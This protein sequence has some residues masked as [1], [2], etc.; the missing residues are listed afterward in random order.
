LSFCVG[1]D[2]NVKAVW[3]ED[4]IVPYVSEL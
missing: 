4:E 2:S 1:K 3:D